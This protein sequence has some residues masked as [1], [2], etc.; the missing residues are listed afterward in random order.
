[1]RCLHAAQA[2]RRAS[3]WSTRCHRPTRARTRGQRSRQH[4]SATFWKEFDWLCCKG[5]RRPRAARRCHQATG[6]VIDCRWQAH[7]TTVAA[8]SDSRV[9]GGRTGWKSADRGGGLSPAA[10]IGEAARRA[11][12]TP[13]SSGSMAAAGTR[14]RRKPGRA[15]S[16]SVPRNNRRRAAHHPNRAG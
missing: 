7:G 11:R 6:P 4:H 13:R 12:R 2:I 5:G 10:M 8:S 1:M 15:L 9:D 3:A 14:R 16:G